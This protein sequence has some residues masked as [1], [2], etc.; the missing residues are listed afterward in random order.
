LSAKEEFLVMSFTPPTPSLDSWDIHHAPDVDWIPWGSQG[1]AQ[2]K[3]L[4]EVD[5]YTVALIQAEAGYQTA[6]HDHAYPEFFYLLDGVIR[7][8][9]QVM[10][11]GD[12]YAAGAAS[13]HTDFETQTAAS[14]ISIFR[15]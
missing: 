14:Y 12:A 15:L 7:N 4:A 3:V 9:G 11:A 8:Q 5:G 13:T 2:A 10:N 1:N 6:A